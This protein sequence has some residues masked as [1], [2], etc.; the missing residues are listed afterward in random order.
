[1]VLTGDANIGLIPGGGVASGAL[2]RR[3]KAWQ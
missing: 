3:L 2:W 1:L